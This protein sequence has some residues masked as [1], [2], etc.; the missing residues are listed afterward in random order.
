VSP[1]VPTTTTP[2]T[3]SHTHAHT[4]ASTDPYAVDPWQSTTP[5][6]TTPAVD[7]TGWWSATQQYSPPVIKYVAEHA[8]KTI[9]AVCQIS[10]TDSIQLAQAPGRAV[11]ARINLGT[12]PTLLPTAK[13]RF[14]VHEYGNSFGN[15]ATSTNTCKNIGVE[16]NP[17]REVNKA[18]MPNPYQNPLRGRLQTVTTDATSLVTEAR[19]YDFMANLSGHQS[20]I[21]R[22]IA[23]YDVA[24]EEAAAAGV[25][26]GA[27]ATA[28]A[29]IACCTVGHDV[30]P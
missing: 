21:G 12:A 23:I 13:Y 4:H 26:P 1:T 24:A 15:A 27:T 9:Y 19:Q 22:T 11:M 16:Y 7:T 18:G 2:T 28:V 29:P 8:S 14:Q 20:I 25:T 10:E 6:G 30:D 3:T 17:L 5:S